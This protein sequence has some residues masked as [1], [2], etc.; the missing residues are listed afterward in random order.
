MSKAS[1]GIHSLHIYHIHTTHAHE[2]KY[3]IH[4]TYYTY[5]AHNTRTCN[6]NLQRQH[7]TSHTHTQQ[8]CKPTC[9]KHMCVHIHILYASYMHNQ[10]YIHILDPH[11]QHQTHTYMYIYMSHTHHTQPTPHMHKHSFHTAHYI[12]IYYIICSISPY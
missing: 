6:H 10:H 7:A 2:N 8:T 4:T 5:R 9:I 3:P 1:T 11:R 12:Y